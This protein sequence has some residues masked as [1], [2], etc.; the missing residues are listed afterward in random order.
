MKPDSTIDGSSSRQASKNTLDSPSIRA[1]IGF[2]LGGS[3]WM[4]LSLFGVPMVFH[5]D[6]MIG[7][8]PFLVLGALLFL[9][10]PGRILA[11]IQGLLMILLLVVAYTPAVVGSARML[12]RSDP[13]PTRVD[14]VVVLSAGVSVDGFLQAQGLDRLL[15]GL[16]LIRRGVAPLLIV[17]REER[18]LGERTVSAAADQDNLIALAGVV[19]FVATPLAAS[20]HDEA[21]AVKNI[22]DRSGWKRIILVTS[23]FHTKRACATFEHVGLAVSC[24]PSDSRDIA[25]HSLASPRDRVSAFSTWIYELA[26][27]L[28][29]RRR[30]WI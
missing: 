26:A 21:M 9:T 1:V 28:Q 20:T 29:Y 4:T 18:D 23:P 22:A 30:G 11:W 7:L 14:A 10:R 19:K 16:A 15:T 5:L 13:V 8:I 25:I 3:I 24:V 27:T 17:T 6:G 2:A 12:I